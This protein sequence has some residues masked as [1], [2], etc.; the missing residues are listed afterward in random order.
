M[1]NKARLTT[2][3]TKLGTSKKPNKA[4][5]PLVANPPHGEKGDFV[6]ITVTL[7]PDV[8]GLIMEEVTRRK[9]TKTANPQISAVLR[10]AAIQYL[11]AG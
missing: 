3:A 8:Y 7:P 5:A 4:E 6:K 10:E 11:K 9:M 2:L 1:T